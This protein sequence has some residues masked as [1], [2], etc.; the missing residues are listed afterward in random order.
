MMTNN[1]EAESARI[2]SRLSY[3]LLSSLLQRQST[4][5]AHIRV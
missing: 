5:R 2:F 1:L 3:K 4:N